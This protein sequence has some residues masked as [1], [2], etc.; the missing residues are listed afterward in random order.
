MNT[1]KWSTFEKNEHLSE[2]EIDV[3]HLVVC[4]NTYVNLNTKRAK[5]DLKA[6]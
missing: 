1:I 3:E 4:T 5:G 2:D 6:N